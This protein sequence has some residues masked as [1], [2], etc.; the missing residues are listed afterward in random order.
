[1]A[2]A[3]DIITRSLRR[4]RVISI[5]DS[6]PAEIAEHALTVFNDML[7]GYEADNLLTE[8]VE[9]TGNVSAGS[10]KITNLDNANN[11]KNT[12]DIAVGMRV[13]G[14]G[15]DGQVDKILSDAELE[16]T[17]PATI[18]GTDVP[19]TFNALPMDDSLTEAL[20]SV[21][22]VRLAEDFGST[23]GPI[24][25]RDARRGQHQIDGVFLK[26]PTDGGVDHALINMTSRRNYEDG[27]N[28]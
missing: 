28:G 19:I 9:I 7:T 27:Y 3:R 21:L 4:I 26:V 18:S 14:A 15:L 11:L 10:R 25:A 23:V 17:V 12:R 24:L 1:M 6:A 2:T 16:L 13:L 5:I 22:A 20:V 8:T